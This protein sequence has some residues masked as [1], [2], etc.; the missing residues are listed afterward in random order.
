MHTRR[1]PTWRVPV[2]IS[3]VCIAVIVL[4]VIIIPHLSNGIT[5][6]L[7]EA[8]AAVLGSLIGGVSGIAGIVI[9]GFIGITIIRRDKF[10]SDDAEFRSICAALS[11][12]LADISSVFRVRSKEIGSQEVNEDGIIEVD[13]ETMPRFCTFVYEALTDRIGLLGPKL[14]RQVVLMYGRT[15]VWAKY[16]HLEYNEK[17]VDWSIRRHKQLSEMTSKLSKTLESASET[18]IVGLNSVSVKNNTSPSN[19]VTGN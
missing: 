12:E 7:S 10:E 2:A 11:A 8:D 4:A 6:G 17:T 13:F 15:L 18:G 3:V 5:L 9:S 19:K 1:K 16:S 14:T